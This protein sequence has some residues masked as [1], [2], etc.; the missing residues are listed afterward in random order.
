MNE[1]PF[2]PL[3]IVAKVLKINPSLLSEDS[4]MGQTPNWD[5]LNHIAIIVE[6]EKAYKVEISDA[7]ISNLVTIRSILSYCQNLVLSSPSGNDK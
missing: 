2:S 6:L 1:H 7:D 5:S 4:T 3:H